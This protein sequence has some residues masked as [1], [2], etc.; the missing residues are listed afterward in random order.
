MTIGTGLVLEP[1]VDVKGTT[2]F[3]DLV[4]GCG[5]CGLGFTVLVKGCLLLVSD[6]RS[7]VEDLF[8]LFSWFCLFSAGSVTEQYNPSGQGPEG[9]LLSHSDTY[10][11]LPISVYF[12]YSL[13]YSRFHREPI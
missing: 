5:G 10:F 13:F 2:G 9:S 11:I 8:F 4:L 12:L 6:L 7:G 1:L 3:G